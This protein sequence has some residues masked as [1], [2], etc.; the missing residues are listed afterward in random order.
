MQTRQTRN[1]LIVN[2]TGNYTFNL[3]TFEAYSYHWWCFIKKVNGLIIYN[4]YHYSQS[5]CKHQSEGLKQINYNYDLRVETESSLSDVDWMITAMESER[6]RVRSL[7]RAIRKPRS[8]KAKNQERREQIKNHLST[9]N[10]LRE[11]KLATFG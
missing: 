1:N 2:S 5:T 6:N 3:N 4:G 11:L 8:H 10:K 7:I 9:L